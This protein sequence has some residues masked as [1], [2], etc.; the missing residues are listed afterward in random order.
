MEFAKSVELKFLTPTK[1]GKTNQRYPVT[2][3][4]PNISKRPNQFSKSYAE[5]KIQMK[6]GTANVSVVLGENGMLAMLGIGY[7]PKIW[8][9]VLIQRMS[10]LK[11]RLII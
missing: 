1:V 4:G 6:M 8:Q 7:L 5:C 11:P 2:E 10:I 9:H 3:I